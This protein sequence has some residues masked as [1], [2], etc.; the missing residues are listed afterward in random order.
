MSNTN[1]TASDIPDLSGKNIIVTG[2]NSGLGFE[3]VK[4]FA[5]KG[6]DVVL[7]S[8]SAEK[9]TKAREDII[10]EFPDSRIEVMQLDLGD[11]ESVRNFAGEFTSKYKKLDILLNNAGIMMSP[12]FKTKD[13]FEGQLGTNHLGH[14]A[15]TG[16][17]LDKIL[18]T[19][20]S[21]DS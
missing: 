8:R 16:L 9:G 2:G 17:L 6:A 4:A 7:A 11:L 20:G 21:R 14:F 13:G 15:L 1:W 5:M 3:S 10:K 19:P 12:Y 18:N